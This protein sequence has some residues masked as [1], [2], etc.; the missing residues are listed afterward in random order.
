MELTEVD[1]IWNRA[2]LENGGLDARHGDK[3]LADLLL[4]HGM[5]MNG[6][7]LHAFDVLTDGER[8]AAFSGY[9]TFG[10]DE[11]VSFLIETEDLSEEDQ[12]ELSWRY[13][14]LVSDEILGRAFENY[15]KEKPE[16]FASV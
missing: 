2:C 3:A 5:A 7:L 6:G 13:Y 4:F 15:Y 12:D 9:R 10:F 11:V 1:K 14:E 16:A 8:A